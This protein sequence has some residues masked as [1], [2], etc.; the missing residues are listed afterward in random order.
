MAKKKRSRTRNEDPD[1]RVL[2]EIL[3]PKVFLDDDI[4]PPWDDSILDDILPP[5]DFSALD[6]MLPSLD[7]YSI[8][9]HEGL[10]TEA[11][12]PRARRSRRP[13]KR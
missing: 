3:G 13:K 7:D 8:E 5:L 6:D 9:A 10:N 11:G 12:Q 1:L 4:I 2:D